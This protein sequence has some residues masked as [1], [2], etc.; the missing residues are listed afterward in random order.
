MGF[1]CFM[2]LHK[3]VRIFQVGIYSCEKIG[4]KSFYNY[5]NV[6]DGIVKDYLVN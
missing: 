4:I 6:I 2:A 3:N 5:W 1:V